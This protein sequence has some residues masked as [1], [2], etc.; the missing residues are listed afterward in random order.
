[1]LLVCGVLH[2]ALCIYADGRVTAK[3]NALDAAGKPVRAWDL[4]PPGVPD[5]ENAAPLYT[6]AA[7]WVKLHEYAGGW[8]PSAAG[9]ESTLSIGY[10]DPMASLGGLRGGLTPAELEGL[11]RL[12]ALDRPALDLIREAARRPHCQFERNWYQPLGVQP[13]MRDPHRV[14]RFLAA[15]ALVAERTGQDELALEC[16]RLIFVVSRHMAEEPTVLAGLGSTAAVGMV[17]VAALLPELRLPADAANALAEELA[18]LDGGATLVERWDRERLTGLYV[19]RL[20]KEREGRSYVRGQGVAP[21]PEALEWRFWRRYGGA[22]FGPWRDMDQ[23][24]YLEYMDGWDEVL[25]ASI[26]ER[27]QAWREIESHGDEARA[28]WWAPA[29]RAVAWHP[30]WWVRS[31]DAW[32]VSLDLLRVVVGLEYYHQQNRAYPASLQ[33]LRA[34]GWDVPMDRFGEGEFVYKPQGA[35][36]VLYSV[37]P[38]L[39]DDGGEPGRW[40]FGRTQDHEPADDMQCDIVWQYPHE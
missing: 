34:S 22:L 7:A 16:L 1:M 21:V 28:P 39:V 18:R 23:V 31:M 35:E 3:V 24:R 20:L 26:R 11:T 15:N 12:V 14:R 9:S 32:Q 36:F 4:K 37:G 13:G 17:T 30:V 40:P 38:N 5:N 6:A 25:R 10:Q 19:F 2:I 8:D 29:T 33:Q 27:A